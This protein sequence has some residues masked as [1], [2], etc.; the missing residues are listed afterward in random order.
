MILSKIRAASFTRTQKEPR[1]QE[2]FFIIPAVP[3]WLATLNFYQVQLQI[4]FFK[5]NP[6]LIFLIDTN[7]TTAS[8]I[9]Q[10]SVLVGLTSKV[11]VLGPGELSLINTYIFCPTCEFQPLRRVYHNYPDSSKEWKLYNYNLNGRPIKIGW[12][13]SNSINKYTCSNLYNS[14]GSFPTIITC[15][16]K[17]L[18]KFYNFTDYDGLAEMPQNLPIISHNCMLSP[19]HHLDNSSLKNFIYL[20]HKHDSYKLDSDF[21]E[22]LITCGVFGNLS[23]PIRYSHVD[24]N[25]G[26]GSFTNCRYNGSKT[27][28]SKG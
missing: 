20:S 21:V 16:Q 8:F 11:F 4:A 13:W 22:T 19:F 10:S 25:H 6:D 3:G 15:L 2:I 24:W 23:C 18:R 28:S 14:E 27:R 12:V 7:A 5:E 26:L 1:S 9:P 17:T